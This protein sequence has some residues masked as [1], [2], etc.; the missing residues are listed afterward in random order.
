M[1]AVRRISL[2]AML[3][4]GAIF[5]E[6]AVGVI[7]FDFEDAPCYG[8]AA[9]I[10]SYMEGVCGSDITV[11]GGSVSDAL[12]PDG[13]SGPLGGDNYVRS[14]GWCS[15]SG[16]SMSFEETPITSASFDFGLVFSSLYVYADGEEVFSNGW[17]CWDSGNS[18]TIYFDSPVSTLLFSRGHFG[19]IEMDN[20][21]VTV[22]PEPATVLILGL[23]GLV[24]RKR[25][26]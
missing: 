22:V 5:A 19:E 10:E 25:R 15:S 18:G 26:R 4:L 21:V 12:W 1:G 6:E 23:G 2:V 17:R 16:F 20:L 9:E 7:V 8:G 14:W 24:L 11:V 13:I 3:V